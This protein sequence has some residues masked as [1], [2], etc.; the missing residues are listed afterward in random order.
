MT[1]QIAVVI[2]SWNVR[3]YTRACVR[4]LVDDSTEKEIVVVDN[5]SSD[6]TVAALRKEFPEINIIANATNRGFAGGVNQG[7][8]AT[9]AP[10]I[11]LLNP[12]TRIVPG[13]LAILVEAMD[14]I[15]GP[16]IF[17]AHLVNEAGEAVSSIRN[18]PTWVNQ[19]GILLKVHR[20]FPR[21]FKH[22]FKRGFDYK[23]EQ[24]VDQVMGSAMAIRRDAWN[25]L[26]GFDETFF[27]WFEEVDFC[28]RA[29]DLGYN[30]LYSPSVTVRDFAGKSF[31]Q[32]DA[33]TKAK[34]FT[35][36]LNYYAKKHWS[37][38]G[39]W[40]I[41]LAGAVHRLMAHGVHAANIKPEP[42]PQ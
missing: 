37:S 25:A 15:A 23:K 4:A 34:Y 6:G 36:S 38:F 30:I 27:I 16:S 8:V 35:D 21:L 40:I 10:I 9:A 22:Y 5:A 31:V 3:E 17:G 41:R 29:R 32:V 12:D 13:S 18:N 2:V 14:H 7:V 24:L 1:P 26:G 39:Q 19:A 28:K 42:R 33:K 20:I 11:F